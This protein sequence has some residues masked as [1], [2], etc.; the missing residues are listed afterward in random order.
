MSQDRCLSTGTIGES[1][2]GI[3]RG[4]AR[5]DIHHVCRSESQNQQGDE[6]KMGCK[7]ERRLICT[8]LP[9][10]ALASGVQ[11]RLRRNKTSSGTINSPQ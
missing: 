7:E 4:K 5:K 10:G 2:G 3:S 9:D 1:Q 6:S 11:K 8:W